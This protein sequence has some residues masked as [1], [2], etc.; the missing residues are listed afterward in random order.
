[1]GVRVYRPDTRF[2]GGMRKSIGALGQELL[3]FRSHILTLFLSDF[4]KGYRGTTLGVFWNFVLPVIP[5]SVYIMLVSLR[6]FPRYDGIPPAAYIGFNV[7]IWYLLTGF[8]NQPMNIVKSRNA[9]VMKTAIPL[10][11]TLTASF[12]QL[13]FDS[14]VRLSVVASII[15]FT[16]APFKLTSPL[17]LLVVFCAS[18]FCLGF[19]MLASILNVIYQDV[20][21]VI[22]I[23]LQYG[24]FLSGVIFPLSTLGP[25]HVL[26]TVNPLSVFI[27]ATREAVFVGSLSHPI[28]LAVWTAIGL[29]LFCF[30]A[31]YFY[32]MEYRIRGL[33]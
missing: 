15:I 16:A 19:G 32:L 26:E 21:R 25:L 12:A 9:E 6:V 20:G 5:I 29:I 8:I 7:T 4:R 3:D 31:R 28:A 23:L 14:L 24:I 22:S 18:I 27:T 30:S 17:A 33:A 10:S 11:A 13:A 2:E 1:M